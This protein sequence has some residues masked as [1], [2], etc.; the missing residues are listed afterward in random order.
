MQPDLRRCRDHDVIVLVA[1]LQGA[2]NDRLVFL[3]RSLHDVSPADQFIAG[4]SALPDFPLQAGKRAVLAYPPADALR[5]VIAQQRPLDHHITVPFFPGLLLIVVNQ[6]PVPGDG[7]K[8]ENLSIV[9]MLGNGI[10]FRT[11]FQTI[12]WG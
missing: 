9:R 8:H 11:R 2:D 4:K 3:H 7:A 10:N 12:P 5:Q 1:D 6:V